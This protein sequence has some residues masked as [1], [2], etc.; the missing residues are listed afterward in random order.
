MKISYNWLKDYVDIKLS[1]AKLAELLTMAGLCVDSIHKKGDD[2]VL[3]IE[4]TSNRPDWLSY[5]GI[6]REVA[7]ITG[8]K[9]KVPLSRHC[10]S[11]RDLIA[12]RGG[13]KQSK[14]TR[15]LRTSINSV[16]S[17]ELV[18]GLRRPDGLPAMTKES[19]GPFSQERISVK[20]VDKKL[21]PRYTARVI[22]NVKV[23]ES[24]KW[25]K[26][27]LEA[28]GL[29]SVNN[30]VDITNFCLFE[31]GEPMH[32]FDLDKLKTM[33]I[34]V[35]RASKGEKIRTIDGV[36][37]LLDN[38][39]L[40]IADDKSPVA[41]A[42]VM[43][44]LY[45]E[46]GLQTKN[47]L[48]EA[49]CFDP[50]S[51][52]RTSRKLALSTDS[53]Y[54]FERKVDIENIE[55]ASGRA[56]RLISELAQGEEAGEFIDTGYT[57]R[58][59]KKIG[60][61]LDRLNKIIGV[62]I[63]PSRVK[64]ILTSLGLKI[65]SSSKN[66][67]ELK[68]P[69]FRYDLQNEIDIIEEVARIYGYE[70][71]PET[72]PP[73]LEA[74]S[75]LPPDTAIDRNIRGVLVNLGLSE[76]ITYS[77]LSRKT[78]GLAGSS[79]ANVINIKNPLSNEQEVMRPTLIAGM[80]N[81]IRWNINRK[82]KDLKFFELGRAYFKETDNSF[83]E[84]K[85]L[86]IGVTGQLYDGW[87]GHPRAV[88]LF[89]LKGIVETL[90]AEIGVEQIRV[91]EAL[92]PAFSPAS[93]ACIE[94]KGNAVGVMGQIDPGVAHNFDIKEAVY[95]AEIDCA[96]LIKYISLGRRF[97]EIPKFPSVIRDI[98]IAADKNILNADIISLIK[99]TAGD[100]LK[101]A[102]LVDRY[103]GG[104]IPEGKIGLTYRLEYQD[105]GRTLQDPEIQAVHSRIIKALENNLGA[106]L[107]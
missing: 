15:L 34:I 79:G 36:E 25:L 78:L 74:G 72:I 55:G 10:E 76:I 24:P 92:N 68:P 103:G 41:I 38:E 31:T 58:A 17:P 102:E 106:K 30:I 48:L 71:I 61:R 19:Q 93:C 6:A 73:V 69:G 50:I 89:D 7:A 28:V 33:S 95:A 26:D 60:L 1:P 44:S 80:L 63:S 88:T 64:S 87:I 104:Q 18:E 62:E 91:K 27:K 90:F 97:K 2:S 70:N 22:R 84:K 42:G 9:L 66:V 99:G 85:R 52:R 105:P 57:A 75:R 101:G 32:A 96:G 98:S 83:A 39:M 13:T 59:L 14:K 54:R 11:R 47:I 46:V 53:G 49:A 107:R 94:V 45:A 67:L 3:E 56:A 16:R 4:I 77:L 20:V 29:R 65:R 51:V 82:L 37:R 43:G 21:C 23:G 8:R 81:S 12:H 5:I 86:A 40:V 35:R 100:I